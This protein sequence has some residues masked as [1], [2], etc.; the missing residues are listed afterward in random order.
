MCLGS[1]LMDHI[2]IHIVISFETG[3][4]SYANIYKTKCSQS[5]SYKKILVNSDCI[6]TSYKPSQNNTIPIQVTNLMSSAECPC[7]WLPTKSFHTAYRCWFISLSS[8]GING[9][10]TSWL[11]GS[12]PP[13]CRRL[14]IVRG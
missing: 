12:L 3:Y 11:I 7:D 6:T 13:T 8:S 9:S 10:V 4:F 2:Y 5:Y 1:T 14:K